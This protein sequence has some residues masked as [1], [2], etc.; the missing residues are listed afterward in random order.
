[1]D[2]I[3]C[4]LTS[5]VIRTSR[6]AFRRRLL[7]DNGLVHAGGDEEFPGLTVYAF[8]RRQPW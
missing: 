3:T 2:R 8:M 4:R 6:A 7:G 1:L 5:T